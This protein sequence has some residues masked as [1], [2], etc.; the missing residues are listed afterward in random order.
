MTARHAIPLLLVAAA[1]AAYHNSFSGPFIFD[2]FHAVVDNPNVRRLWPITAAM[3][4]PPGSAVAGRPLVSLTLAMNYA[5]GGLNVRGYHAVNLV[6]HIAA[7]LVLYGL[8]RR[9]LLLEPLRRRYGASADVVAAAVALLWIVH[10]LTTDTVTY[11]SNRSEGLAG[12][13]MLLALY[14][15]NR[16]AD[17]PRRAIWRPAVVVAAALGVMSKEVAAVT[18]LLVLLYDRAFLAGSFA[19]ALRERRW[20]YAGLAATWLVTI[21]LLMSVDLVSKSGKRGDA[22]TPWRYLLTQSGA[23]VHYLRLCVW[24]RPL[25]VDYDD[26]PIAH[27]L[28]QVLVPALAVTA[29]L[30]AT[31]WALVRRPGIGFVAAAFF[32]VLAPTSSFLPLGTEVVAERRMYLPLA[33]VVTLA[34]LAVARIAP[35]RTGV[36]TA[37]FVA[38][39][40]SVMTVQR[41]AVYAT[42]ISIWADNVAHRP[43]N[44][45]A[46]TSLGVAL[47]AN[48]QNDEAIRQYRIVLDRRPADADA[49]YNL[50]N[51]LLRERPAEAIAH[52]QRAVALRPDQPRLRNNYGVALAQTGRLDQAEQQFREAIRLRPGLPD[53]HASLARLLLMK[54]DVDGAIA[55]YEKALD[56]DPDFAVARQGLAAAL[57]RKNRGSE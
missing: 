36:A 10:P 57:D 50:A 45:R 54:N 37:A 13:F 29:M 16:S 53:P 27:A 40:F 11:I 12:L 19:G 44:T 35:R 1:V 46:R 23:I 18:P 17:A 38:V 32:V 33:A 3:D 47:A 34:V 8:V 14:A 21:A 43:N 28:P 15:C 41:N 51:V 2:D 9:T 4:A 55:E 42:A 31:I 25:V 56:C 24:P 20:M 52:Y 49:H 26:W 6:L 30:A 7:G 5:I 39:V 22:I 48:R